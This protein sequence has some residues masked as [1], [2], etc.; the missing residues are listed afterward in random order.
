MSEILLVGSHGAPGAA[1]DIPARQVRLSWYVTEGD[2]PTAVLT[3]ETGAVVDRYPGACPGVTADG[4]MWLLDLPALSPS[5]VAVELSVTFRS[6]GHAGFEAIV[7][8]RSLVHPGAAG[9]PGQERL[10]ARLT[11]TATGW[12]PL[13]AKRP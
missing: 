2:N 13:W 10:V 7:G 12:S 5:V 3:G 8:D 9:Q 11:R 6:S 4:A 1:K